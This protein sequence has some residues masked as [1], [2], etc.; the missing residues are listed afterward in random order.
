MSLLLELK[1]LRVVLDGEE[2]PAEVLR[3]VDLS[4][5]AGERVALVGESGCGKSVTALSLLDL[6]PE[7]PMRRTG[8]S[9]HFRGRD[10]FEASPEEW[11]TVRGGGIAMIFQ[12]P[13][14]SLNPVFRAGDQ[15]AEAVRMHEAIGPQPARERTL[16]LFREVGLPDPERVADAYPHQLS[17]G[18]CQRVMVAMALAGRP[19]LLVA[20]EP[21]TALDVTVQAQ[22]L[23]LLSRLSGERGMGVLLITHDLSLVGNLADRVVILYAGMV[24]EVGAPGA[25]FRHARH[26][27]TAGL[28]ACHPALARRG[29][30]MATLPGSVPGPRDRFPGCPFA[31]RCPR[32]QARCARSLPTLE[33][34]SEGHG[35]RCFYPL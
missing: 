2:G 10:L 21:T 4:L 22:I 11:R 14:T 15:V 6:L 31:P 9:L 16:S 24:V 34:S 17:G 30:P 29:E 35:T 27:Y 7:P 26:P 8:G 5:N 1:D 3:G 23:E 25:I 28:L 13:L 20:D 18:M 32:A 19:A 33:T 12:E